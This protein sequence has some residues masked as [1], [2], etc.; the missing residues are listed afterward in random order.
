MISYF[1]LR[2]SASSVSVLTK[3]V[4]PVCHTGQSS[5]CVQKLNLV[6][7]S[8]FIHVFHLLLFL[9]TY[10]CVVYIFSQESQNSC[11]LMVQVLIALRG[12]RKVDVMLT[13]VKEDLEIVHLED[14][15]K[16]QCIGTSQEVTCTMTWK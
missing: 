12:G 7:L 16:G 5:I 4:R 6:I 15:P 11:H 8:S 1:Q 2:I 3:S 14:N 9:R 10:T 13:L